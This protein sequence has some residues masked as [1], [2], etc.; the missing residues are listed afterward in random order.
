ML[1]DGVRHHVATEHGKADCM[2]ENKDTMG[3][4][5]SPNPNYCY[6]NHQTEFESIA[7]KCYK[8]LYRDLVASKLQETTLE[9]A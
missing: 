7:T 9:I 4:K 1:Q 5:V 6:I 2:H 3:D 8:T